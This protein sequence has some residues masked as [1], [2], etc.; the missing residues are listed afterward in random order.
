MTAEIKLLIYITGFVASYISFKQ[1]WIYQTNRWTRFD[2]LFGVFFSLLS[3]VG[4]LT[5]LIV[6]LLQKAE[7]SDFWK[8]PAKF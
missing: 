6:W 5:S 8:K 3:W 4:A 2:V 1:S 7:D